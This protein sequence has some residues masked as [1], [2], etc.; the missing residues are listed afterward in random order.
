MIST[1]TPAPNRRRAAWQWRRARKLIVA[2]GCVTSIQPSWAQEPQASSD[3]PKMPAP[4]D[5]AELTIGAVLREALQKSPEMAE[6]K[7]RSRAAREVSPAESR[8]PDPQF[9]YRLWGQPLARPWAL[10]EAQMHMFELRQAFPAP[11]SSSQLAEAGKARSEVAEQSYRARQL[12]LRARVIRAYAAYYLA[13]REYRLHV[14]HA[15]LAREVIDLARGSYQAGRGTQQDVLRA[16]LELSRLH[17]AVTGVEAERRTAQG[18]LN[19]LM[20]RAVDAPLGPPAAIPTQLQEQAPER[21]PDSRPEIAAARGAMKAEESEAAAKRATSRWP[22]FMVGIDYMYT[23][24]SVSDSHNYGV[25]LSMSL[26]WFNP[27]YGEETRAA[28]ARVAAERSA[29]ESARQAANYELF[30][31]RQRLQAATQS[32]K[33]IETDIMP[34]A[35]RNFEAAQA[36]YRGGQLDSMTLLDA[37]SSLLDIRSERER[38]IARVLVASADV[39]RATGAP[40]SSSDRSTRK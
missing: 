40:I 4:S 33:T 24:T 1:R 35:E 2:I 12:D 17:N 25:M 13:D 30:A 9:E 26:P 36:S 20:G 5:E 37:L 21:S 34:Q 8:L 14:A 7:A 29:L 3:Q 15:Q 27:R 11:G 19:T 10:D 6:A 23:P 28:E 39:D 32:L 38:A 31:A 18:L 16:N 22:S